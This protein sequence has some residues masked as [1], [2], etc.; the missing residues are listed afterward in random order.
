MNPD[1]ISVDEINELIRLVGYGKFLILLVVISL[2]FNVS[3]ILK[4]YFQSK[5]GDKNIRILQQQISLL[6]EIKEVL[7]KQYIESISIDQC[8]AILRPLIIVSTNEINTMISDI[9][10]N[11]NLIDNKVN[12]EIKMREQ[13]E[14]LWQENKSIL[15][16]FRYKT[17]RLHEFLDESWKEAIYSNVERHVFGC[18]GDPI[19]Q[20]IKT[21]TRSMKTQFENVK[22]MTIES[23]TNY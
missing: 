5:K 9:I 8:E 7:E 16:K 11:N 2:L 10:E 17:R 12:I 21:A 20:K 18:I 14:H 19:D 3:M 1:G 23:I 22:L 13:I 15:G 6:S 4:W